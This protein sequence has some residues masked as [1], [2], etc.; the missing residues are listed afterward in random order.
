[1]FATKMVWV[2]VSKGY[3]LEI[4]SQSN[5]IIARHKISLKKGQIIMLN[6][7]YRG[8]KNEHGNWKRLVAMFNQRYPGHRVFL[9]KLQAQKRINARYQLGRIL[10]IASYY[11]PE[12]VLMAIGAA[13]DYNVF[14]FYFLQGYLENH[15]RHDIKIPETVPLRHTCYQD[16]SVI[17]DLNT[18]ALKDG[19]GY[20]A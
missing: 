5:K 11:K 17:R 12:Q 18:Y 1:M 7:H 10:E 8:N 13:L 4:Y 16:N 14:N 6:E 19:G 15:F 3:F 2:K 20:E 9:D